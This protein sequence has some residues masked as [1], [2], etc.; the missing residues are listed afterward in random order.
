MSAAISIVLSPAPS[1]VNVAEYV[2]AL[3]VKEL[4]VPPE[5]VISPSTKS[6]VDLLDVNFKSIV[7]SLVELPSVT[8]L[9]VLVI[10]IIGFEPLETT[11]NVAVL[12]FIELYLQ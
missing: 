12:L 4:K 1:G 11:L 2:V 6:D 9:V 5:T 8:P 10:V 7:A 3:P